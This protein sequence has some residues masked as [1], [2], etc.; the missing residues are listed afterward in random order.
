MKTVMEKTVMKK[1]RVILM[2]MLA[3][4][5]VTSCSPT[6]TGNVVQTLDQ[7]Q[8]VFTSL[9]EPTV[10]EMNISSFRFTPSKVT[11]KKGERILFTNNNG[12]R[13]KVQEESYRMFESP[14]M[15]IGESYLHTFTQKGTYTVELLNFFDEFE[16]KRRTRRSRTVVTGVI[17]V[18]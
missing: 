9:K 16:T 18:R 12:R 5:V 15:E 4:M 8:P 10:H 7:Q 1:V 3:T 11:I 2:I 17:E 6:P 14:W 13:H